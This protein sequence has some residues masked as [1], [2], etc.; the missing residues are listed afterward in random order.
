M[1]SKLFYP[2]NQA[3]V[4]EKPSIDA[5]TAPAKAY[6]RL[7]AAFEA[8]IAS[9]MKRHGVTGLSVAIVDDQSLVWARGFGHMDLEANLPATAATQYRAGHIG[10]LLTDVVAMRFVERGS[11]ALDM[12]L[13]EALP[14]FSIR[15]RFADA[16]PITVRDL[17]T[18]HAGLPDS[19]LPGQ[20][21]ADP[22]PF[23]TLVERLQ[24]QYCAYPP[25]TMLT[26]SM[27]G[28]TLLGHALE[29]IADMPFAALMR[30]QL[31][32]PLGMH[33]S[34]FT[35]SP[36][37]TCVSKS[38]RN[39]KLAHERGLRDVPA[40][41]LNSTVIDLSRFM[42]FIF[43]E[44]AS[45][46]QQMLRPESVR[47]M[48]ESQHDDATL[49]CGFKIGLGWMLNRNVPGGGIVA[50][51]DGET[52]LQRSQLTILPERKLGVVFMSNSP[53]AI[54]FI[55]VLAESILTRLTALK[56]GKAPPPPPRAAVRRAPAA[57]DMIARLV[58]QYA[59]AAGY[60]RISTA[61][62]GLEMG[63]FGKRFGLL[64]R[65]DGRFDFRYKLFGVLNVQ[66]PRLAGL[67]LWAQA[68]DDME[69][70]IGASKGKTL[71][72]AEKIVP[73]QIP[74]RWRR[75]AG[76]LRI[77]N[78]KDDAIKFTRISLS[79]H[80]GFMMF[81]FSNPMFIFGKV[82][83][84]LGIVSDSEAIILGFGRGKRETISV[85]TENGEEVI[86]YA[87]YRLIPDAPTHFENK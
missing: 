54:A 43:A 1:L 44:G 87:G 68:A 60:A 36:T 86:E 25:G 24:D 70:L 62:R 15:T 73:A 5:E 79:V 4:R 27:T 49:D 38:Y 37:A 11:L 69:L 34:L 10:N 48:F 75:L 31:L 84:P 20:W 52:M 80:E 65:D 40:A 21:T 51:H 56:H 22:A 33:D 23:T 8:E 53:G 35:S 26:Y 58:G 18:H 42:R 17:M 61:G 28:A 77:T 82:S 30:E 81:S 78:D 50:H 47:A 46:T 29:N 45:G 57:P 7:C 13:S 67:E 41:G 76:P 55:A 3:R 66:P 74:E 71:V 64:A 9:K 63:I 19:Y 59:T 85:R 39:G 83:A 6:E 16:R 32:D 14:A 12:P 72:F 2:L